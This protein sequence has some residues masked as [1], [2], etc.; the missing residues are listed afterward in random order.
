MCGGKGERSDEAPAPEHGATDMRLDDHFGSG[1]TLQRK[2]EVAARAS[3]GP[4]DLGNCVGSL[5]R[6]EV[7]LLLK[8]GPQGINAEPRHAVVEGME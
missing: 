8:D 1:S 7:E 2:L 3:P 4:G 5:K 6:G